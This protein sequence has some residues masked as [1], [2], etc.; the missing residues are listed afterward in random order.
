MEHRNSHGEV[1]GV[2]IGG[3]STPLA[4]LTELGLA[5]GSQHMTTGLWKSSQRS[6]Q[7]AFAL[8]RMLLLILTMLLFAARDEWSES[9]DI[10]VVDSWNR[11]ELLA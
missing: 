11:I 10:E 3:V 7:V 4:I 1:Y 9:S 2:W 8:P 5:C 6:R